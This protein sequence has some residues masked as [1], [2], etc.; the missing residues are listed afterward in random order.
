[1]KRVILVACA[2]VLV[3]GSFSMVAVGQDGNES[4]S[5]IQAC[6]AKGFDADICA[7]C[8]VAGIGN[9]AQDYGPCYCKF[10]QLLRSQFQTMGACVAF[11]QQTLRP[12]LEA[13]PQ[14]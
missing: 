1:M 4:Q 5:R 9:Q 7:T 2:L 8:V 3:V 10:D 11:V 6:A 13:A 14:Q 12:E